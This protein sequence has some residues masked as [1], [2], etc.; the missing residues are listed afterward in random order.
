[1]RLSGI[2]GRVAVVTGA[3]GV[4]G[5]AVARRFIAEGAR[6]AA[7]D[8]DATGLDRLRGADD[9]GSMRTFDVDLAS[10]AEVAALAESVIGEF[11]QVDFL[12]NVAGG[13]VKPTRAYPDA[14]WSP[15][16][17]PIE[18][19]D[20][21]AW[22]R[23]LDINLTSAFLCCRAF[24]PHMKARRTGRIVNF[25]SFATRNG[26]IRVGAHYAAAK[27][28]IVGLTKT[29][30]LELAPYG[31][32]VNALAPG[33][34]PHQALRDDQQALLGRIPLGRAGTPEEIASVVAVLCSSA[35]SYTSGLTLDVNGGLYIGP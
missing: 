27:G 24:V 7:V 6:L 14:R 19:I 21:T 28:G 35:G 22:A 15:G 31:I 25:A 13:E 10:E 34:V 32:T 5:G 29:L 9:G 17:H 23:T 11:G 16:M 2:E 12:V 3:G 33:L 8:I 20:L 26:S 18:E 1:M 4:I 30:A